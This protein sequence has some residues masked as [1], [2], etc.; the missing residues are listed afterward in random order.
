MREVRL[1]LTSAGYLPRGGPGKGA[2]QVQEMFYILIL[3]G[4]YIMYADIKTQEVDVHWG[5]LK[6]IVVAEVYFKV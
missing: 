6:T 2:S 4:G 5:F 1:V 3:G